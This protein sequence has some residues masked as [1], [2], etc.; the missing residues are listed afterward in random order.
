MGKICQK[1]FH[2]VGWL[3]EKKKKEFWIT[4]LKESRCEGQAADAVSAY[5]EFKMEDAPVLLKIP[6]IRMS[7]HLDTSTKPQMAQILVQFGRP[8]RSS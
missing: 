2:H 3:S 8:S 4:S 1:K 5:T 6:K 7:R